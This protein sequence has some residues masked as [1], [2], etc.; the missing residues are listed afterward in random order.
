MKPVDL[1]GQKFG[2]LTVLTYAGSSQWNCICNC[3]RTIIVR[4][5][6]LKI[7]KNKNCGCISSYPRYYRFSDRSLAAKNF[8]YKN[9]QKSAKFRN[10][11][12]TIKFEDFIK[13]TQQDCYYCGEKPIQLCAVNSSTF[14]YN[15]LDRVD[16]N[17]GYEIDNV[18]TCCKKCNRS[19]WKR[20]E[21]DFVSWVDR[22][23]NHIMLNNL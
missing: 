21:K 7:R 14:V 13:L 18:R 3:G 11:S 6:S 15:G 23:Y 17:K 8:L 22:C 1:I 16:N 9:Y 19:K 2:G 12:F 4:S 20:N 10:H 5:D